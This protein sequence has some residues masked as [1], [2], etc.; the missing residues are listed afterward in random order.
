MKDND[1]QTLTRRLVAFRDARDWQQF[2]SLKNLIISL[3]LEAS[4]LLE[5][6][7]WKSDADFEESLCDPEIK[8]HFEQECADI[9][10]YLLLV[11]ERSGIDLVKVTRDKIDAN[12]KK[13]PV[14]KARGNSKKYTQL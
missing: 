10:A 6:T 8:Q 4:E 1:L 11:A 5:L 2:H 7:Q 9:F 3:N 13:Y 12:D 14:A